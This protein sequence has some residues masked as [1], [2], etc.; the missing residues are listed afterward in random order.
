MAAAFSR[1]GDNAPVM[2][3]KNGGEIVKQP[4][5]VL[6]A[7]N[8]KTAWGDK[9]ANLSRIKSL[10]RQAAAGDVGMLAF[11]EMALSGYQCQSDDGCGADGLHHRLAE[12]IPGP[13]TNE[14][15][16]LAKELDIYVILGMPERDP[17]DA[18]RV[19]NSAAVIGPE[20]VLGAYRKLHLGPAVVPGVTERFCFTPG[21]H[22]MTEIPVFQTRY[23]A[24]GVSICYDFFKFPE[25]CRIQVMKGARILINCTATRAN[26]DD[27]PGTQIPLVNGARAYENLAFVATAN[28]TGKEKTAGFC[29]HSTIAGPA[30]QVDGFIYAEGDGTESIVSAELD[31]EMLLEKRRIK[32]F[33][34]DRADYSSRLFL[35]E[36]QKLG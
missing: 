24:I 16:A 3:P 32:P 6:G 22:G 8:F 36:F 35:S 2:P 18:A 10:L 25:I 14:I 30:P 9:A 21:A 15:A 17:A 31:L 20:G 7:A 29:G 12:T 11:P 27:D 26:G 19:Y 23:G 1:R 4:E 33:L 13:A 5:L 28:L 34:Q